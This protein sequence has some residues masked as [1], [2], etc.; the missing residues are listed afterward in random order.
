MSKE[1]RERIE[2]SKSS[3]QGTITITILTPMTP[4]YHEAVEKE[5]VD[6][7]NELG[8]ASTVYSAITNNLHTTKEI[9]PNEE[10]DYRLPYK[11]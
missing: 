2:Q 3:K 7:L 8:I 4:F 1:S 10:N 9:T 5:I 11:V 6:T